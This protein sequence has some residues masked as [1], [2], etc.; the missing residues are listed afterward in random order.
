MSASLGMRRRNLSSRENP[1]S[2]ARRTTQISTV[3]VEV[4]VEEE[5]E[6]EEEEVEEEEEE[7]EEEEGGVGGWISETELRAS[8]VISEKEA[9]VRVRVVGDSSTQRCMMCLMS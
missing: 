4:G 8:A 5:E 3:A 1:Q 7:E 6:E 2:R 9:V